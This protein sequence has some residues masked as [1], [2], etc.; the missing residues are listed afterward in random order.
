MLRE[1]HELLT[2]ADVIITYNGK[3]FDLPWIKGEFIS[4]GLPPVPP[5]QHIDLYQV[6]RANA[7]FLSNK[8]DYVANKLLGERKVA[9]QGFGLWKGCLNGD[10]T[11]RRKMERYSKQDTAL[12]PKLWD[13][14]RPYT[15]GANAI[16]AGNPLGCPSCGNDRKQSRGYYRT[17]VSQYR[18]YQCQNCGHWFRDKVRHEVNETRDLP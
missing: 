12:L 11:A 3:K 15:T 4:E 14:L 10:P 8:L 18:R 1:L 17:K 13:V 5:V 16:H 2:E 7:R 6:V 9:H